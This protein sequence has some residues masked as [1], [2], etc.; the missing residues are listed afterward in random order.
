MNHL[1]EKWKDRIEDGQVYKR[2]VKDAF[3]G[4]VAVRALGGTFTDKEPDFSF[5]GE[6]EPD[7]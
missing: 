6:E 7:F 3:L 4:M 1:L 5:T 2:M